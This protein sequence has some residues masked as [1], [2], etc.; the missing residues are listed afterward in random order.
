MS[1]PHRPRP[2][3]VNPTTLNPT[4]LN[5]TAAAAAPVPDVGAAALRASYRDPARV[6]SVPA[7]PLFDVVS[8]SMDLGL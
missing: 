1:H 2:A 8:V 7:G 5:P 4:T 6:A 3:A